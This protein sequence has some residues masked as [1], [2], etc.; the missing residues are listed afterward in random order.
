MATPPRDLL[1]VWSIEPASEAICKAARKHNGELHLIA[2]GPLT[3]LAVA[4]EEEPQLPSLLK[5]LTILGGCEKGGNVTPTAEFNLYCDSEAAAQVF[6][7]RPVCTYSLCA[8]D[9]SYLLEHPEGRLYKNVERGCWGGGA[10]RGGWKGM[11]PLLLLQGVG[12]LCNATPLE[13]H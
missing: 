1:R 2:I 3:N 9:A 11:S 13:D 4:V 5:S 7:L 8:F 12:C 6:L 10:V